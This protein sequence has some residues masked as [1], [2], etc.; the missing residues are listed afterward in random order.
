MAR[1]IAGTTEE[2]WSYAEGL[3]DL[4]WCR[5][6]R[7][8]WTLETAEESPLARANDKKPLYLRCEREC[9]THRKITTN[10][11]GE[12]VNAYFYPKD[13]SYPRTGAGP[14]T[15]AVNS[16]FWEVLRRSLGVAA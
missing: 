14:V 15:A 2:D 9:G 13:S 5:T 6:V 11:R 4:I 3:G 12:R 7:H 8:P 16:A 10:R 1:R